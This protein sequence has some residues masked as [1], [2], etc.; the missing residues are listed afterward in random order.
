MKPP[1]FPRLF[2]PSLVKLSPP[3]PPLF[4]TTVTLHGAGHVLRRADLVFGNP[5]KKCWLQVGN[6]MVFIW[7]YHGKIIV[8]WDFEW[9]C[10]SRSWMFMVHVWF[11]K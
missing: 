9:S 2:P 7:E 8:E 1:I 11:E 6:I 10:S 4:L 3:I 5:K